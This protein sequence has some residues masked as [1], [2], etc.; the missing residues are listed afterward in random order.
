[1]KICSFAKKRLLSFGFS[2]GYPCTDIVGFGQAADH[3]PFGSTCM[4]E[5]SILQINAYMGGYLGGTGAACPE[6]DQVAF[7]QINTRDAGAIFLK[8][9]GGIAL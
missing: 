2:A 1:M 5:F 7:P 4:N 3:H 8:D 6:K 9:I